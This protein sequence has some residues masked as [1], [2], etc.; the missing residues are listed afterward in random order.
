MHRWGNLITHGDEFS[1]G[2]GRPLAYT[3]GRLVSNSLMYG[4]DVG[5]VWCIDPALLLVQGL[6]VL[7]S[8]RRIIIDPSVCI[9][10]WNGF[11]HVGVPL[12]LSLSLLSVSPPSAPTGL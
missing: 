10:L 5:V 1:E 9:V 4:D 11:V 12:S 6:M 7:Y 3:L 2:H 8:A